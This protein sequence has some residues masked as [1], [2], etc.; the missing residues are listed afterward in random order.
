M[1][2]IALSLVACSFLNLSSAFAQEIKVAGHTIMSPSDFGVTT[3]KR[4]WNAANCTVTATKPTKI[5][6]SYKMLTGKRSLCQNQ[7]TQRIYVISNGSDRLTL[8]LRQYKDGY[9]FRY[10]IQNMAQDEKVTSIGTRFH[11][12]AS[13]NRWMQQYDGPGYEHFFPLCPGGVSPEGEK[14]VQWGYPALF[15]LNKGDFMLISDSYNPANG[16]NGTLLLN[17]PEDRNTYALKMFGEDEAV[18]GVWQSAWNVVI[19]GSLSDVV[20]STLVTDVADPCQYEDVSWIKP[21]VSS[22][23]YWAY[24]HGSQEYS[25]LKEYVDLAVDMKWPYTLVDAEWDVMRGGNIEQ[26]CK[27]AVDK[28]VMPMIWYNSTTNWT[29][30]WAPT[31]QGLL[32]DPADCDKEFAKI[33][34]WGVKGIKIDFFRNDTKETTDYYYRLLSSAAKNHMLVNFH[35]GTLPHGWQRTYPNVVTCEAVHGAEWYNNNGRFTNKAACHNATLP[36]TR[37]VIGPMDYT[38]GTFT[39]SQHPHITTNAHELALPIL[40]ESGC[41]H[42][43]D[44]P[45]TYRNLPKKIKQLLSELPSTWDDTKLLAGD[46]GKYVVLARR[47]GNNWYIAGINGTDENQV[48]R[49]NCKALKTKAKLAL[50]IEDTDNMPAGEKF[51][52][53][54]AEEPFLSKEDIQFACKPRGG[55]VIKL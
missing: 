23:I 19:T 7:G 9:A 54:V 1:K 21:G 34:S 51:A 22:W 37:N 4:S 12:P 43:P 40:F 33:S 6:E 27:Y 28:G 32:N 39:D 24:N 35:G 10:T 44:R 46:V 11:I 42:M 30:Q 48:I 47:K 55:F 16:N 2:K 25:I 50:V 20:E 14:V 17:T 41:Q 3:N 8:T 53:K 45:D 36:F 26:L 18:N 29:G 5:K 31:P 49:F 15:E 13:A 38:P 52:F